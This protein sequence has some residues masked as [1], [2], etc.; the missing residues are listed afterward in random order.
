MVA[1]ERSY[2]PFF[3]QKII[4]HSAQTSLYM[5][6]PKLFIEGILATGTILAASLA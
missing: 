1:V 5:W 4:N 2:T 6:L 3:V